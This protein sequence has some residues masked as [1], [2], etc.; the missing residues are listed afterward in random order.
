[1]S[2][3]VVLRIV[4]GAEKKKHLIEAAPFGR[5]NQM[6]GLILRTTVQGR[7]G[8]LS[9]PS[10]KSGGLGGSA[11]QPK[12]IFFAKLNLEKEIRTKINFAFNFQG[13]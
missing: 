13:F 6:A 4:S 10:Q 12:P 5:L 11:P 2:D 7:S 1:M 8:G 9:P 3:G